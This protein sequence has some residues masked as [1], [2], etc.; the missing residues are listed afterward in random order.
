MM[1][2]KFQV[3]VVSGRGEGCGHKEAHGQGVGAS[4]ASAMPYFL[5]WVVGA[6]MLTTVLF[7][8]FFMCLKYCIIISFFK[9]L[10]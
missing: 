4:A 1:K 9:K 10:E 3:Q 8:I 5:I 7:L 2:Y 6:W